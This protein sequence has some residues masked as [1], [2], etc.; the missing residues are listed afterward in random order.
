MD[1]AAEARNKAL[2]TGAKGVGAA[3]S[4]GTGTLDRASSVKGKL[5]SGIAE[6]ASRWRG[7][8]EEGEGEG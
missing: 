4:L 5:S 3:R 8:E 1:A 7:N 6:R 2:E